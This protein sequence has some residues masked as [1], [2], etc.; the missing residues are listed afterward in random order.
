MTNETNNLPGDVVAHLENKPWHEP[1]EKQPF[2]EAHV[3]TISKAVGLGIER[4]DALVNALI[5]KEH[6]RLGLGSARDR[7][8]NAVA[9]FKLFLKDRSH[10]VSLLRQGDEVGAMDMVYFASKPL[11]R[12][13][14]RA[15][16]AQYKALTRAL[17]TFRISG[18]HRVNVP[19]VI[20]AMTARAG[21]QPGVRIPTI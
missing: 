20:A 21:Q 18:Y 15:D 17:L 6:E 8:A 3:S 2:I 9:H 7:N 16:P 13:M 12:D 5:A 10:F 1:F 4:L 19:A 14:E 11:E